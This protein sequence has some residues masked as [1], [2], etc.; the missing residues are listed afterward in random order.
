MRTPELGPSG[1]RPFVFIEKVTIS[2]QFH[3]DIFALKLFGYFGSWLMM[4]LTYP[5]EI[6]LGNCSW[7]VVRTYVNVGVD[8]PIRQLKVDPTPQIVRPFGSAPRRISW[9]VPFDYS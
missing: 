4:R 9:P 7:T 6:K 8:P 2:R 1:A 5:H 3:E